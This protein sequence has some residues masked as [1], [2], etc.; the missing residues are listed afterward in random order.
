MQLP[1]FGAKTPYN[2]SMQPP[3]QLSTEAVEEFKAIY[4]DEFGVEL[5]DDEVEESALRLLRFFRILVRSDEIH[6]S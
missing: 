2:F 1:T 4:R 5:P 6:Q 3:Q